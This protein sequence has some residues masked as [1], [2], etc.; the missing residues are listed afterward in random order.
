MAVGAVG[1]IVTR[2]W[3]VAGRNAEVGDSVSGSGFIGGAAQPASKSREI[4]SNGK[5]NVLI[6]VRQGG[7]VGYYSEKIRSQ[8][9][10]L[11]PDNLDLFFFTPNY[12]V[13]LFERTLPAASKV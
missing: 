10:R 13:T 12:F 6:Q 11:R 2:G 1:D 8:P 9:T 4:N 5:F 7:T 3:L